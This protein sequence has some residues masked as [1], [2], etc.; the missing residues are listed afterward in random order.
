VALTKLFSQIHFSF[1]N[2]HHRDA[3]NPTGGKKKSAEP[4]EAVFIGIND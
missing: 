4:E 3:G 1:N 2:Y